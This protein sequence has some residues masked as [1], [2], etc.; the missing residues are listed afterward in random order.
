MRIPSNHCPRIL[1]HY[2]SIVDPA[3]GSGHFLLAAA[4]RL[5]AHVARLQANGTP[6]A[7]EYR[8]ALRQVVARCIYGVDLN[9]MAVELCK[10]SLWME[11][12]EPGLPLTFLDSHIQH[13]N[14]LIGTT[15]EL[16]SGGVPDAAWAPIE[17]DDRKTASLLRRRNKAAASGQRGM[18]ALWSEPSSG[19]AGQVVRAVAELEAAS[20]T[21]AAALA[22]KESRWERIL[23][24]NAYRHQTFVADA[25]CAAFVWPK[26]DGDLADAAPTNVL[27]RQLRDGQGKAPALTAKTVS[28]LAEEYRFFHWHLQFPQVF[29]K[30]GF[31]VVLGNPP[32][33]E[34]QFEETA[35]FASRD[36]EIAGA[37]NAAARAELIL[38]L[39]SANAPLFAQYRAALRLVGGVKLFTRASGVFPTGSSGKLNTATLFTSRAAHLAHAR[40]GAFGLVVP[41]GVATDKGASD[42]FEELMS[43]G[44]LRSL[45]DFVNQRLLFPAVRPHQHFCL[46][47]GARQR[48]AS[49]E[50]EFAAFLLDPSELGDQQRR[51]R[52]SWQEVVT[53]SPEARALSLFSSRTQAEASRKLCDRFA[54]L[55]AQ[56][57]NTDWMAKYQQGTFNM[58]SASDLFR[59]EPDLVASGYKSV[60]L[61]L[62]RAK[63]QAYTPLFDAKMARQF[64]WRAA[65]LGFSGHQF[66]KVSKA[67]STP[68]QLR[69]PSFVPAFTYW[70]PRG[71]AEA[72]LGDWTAPWLLGFKDVTGVTSTRLAAFAFIP[73]IG[74]A[75]AYPLLKLAGAAS[76]HAFVAAWLNG[77]LVEW[78]LRQRMHGLHLTW[79][80]LSQVPVP[81]RSVAH[82]P[83]GWHPWQT[84]AQWVAPRVAELSCTS[85]HLRILA[86]ELVGSEAAFVY[87]DE[88]RFLIR[89]ELDA[90]FFH[91]AG[92]TAQEALFVMDSLD[93]LASREVR[94]FGE[95]RSRKEVP[96]VMS[97]MAEAVRTGKAYQTRLDPPPA[98][99]RVAHP[100]TRGDHP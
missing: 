41:T 16:M 78:F 80:I 9:P 64:E 65:S 49:T 2:I 81:A 63:A 34:V 72:R 60:G 35:W 5:A 69:D 82:G 13:G 74:I 98:D 94:E 92:L 62:E 22:G 32:W 25:W 85:C 26:Q 89:I 70:V 76:D 99:P 96:V 21:D 11:A 24:S 47:T 14:A 46:L 50:A 45:Y 71:E 30:G 43:R 17:G 91:L 86:E 33:D 100:D 59:V 66:R 27:W 42:L 58:A 55:G 75:H 1:G 73:R 23:G 12:V 19:E 40:L 57:N 90:A 15:P 67:P 51:Y 53:L 36:L 93:K 29:A 56:T 83:A 20:D 52:L 44:K 61:D 38:G 4:R 95:Y 8:H 84:V 39:E 87:D 3:C 28:E 31:D 18:T 37:Q 48:E 6:S 7:A 97:A 68:D 10:V 88:R 79:H 54:P 77:L